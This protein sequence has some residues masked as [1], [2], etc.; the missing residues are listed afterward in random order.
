MSF[1]SCLTC[2]AL[3]LVVLP[4]V[5]LLLEALGAS[6]GDSALGDSASAFGV[7]W[8]SSP[9]ERL[10]WDASAASAFLV[11][12]SISFWISLSRCSSQPL[13]SQ[14]PGQPHLAFLAQKQVPPVSL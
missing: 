5:L 12:A 7:F 2:A 6:L 8:S 1:A 9:A 11:S 3:I 13:G 10:L 4:V 14:S